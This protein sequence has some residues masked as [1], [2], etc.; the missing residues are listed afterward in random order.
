M[1]IFEVGKGYEF[2]TLDVYEGNYHG[3]STTNTVAE[4]EG[5]LIKLDDGT[6]INI[7]APTFEGV[8]D[9]AQRKQYADET[10]TAIST[11]DGDF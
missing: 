5:P 7:Q 9:T 3:I 1:A 6:I 4:I 11:H 8:V 2:I 10:R